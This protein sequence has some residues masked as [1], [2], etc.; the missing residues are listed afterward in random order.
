M[1]SPLRILYLEDDPRDAELVLETLALDGITCQLT[2]VENE[3]DFI[4]S[5][6][7]GGFDLILAD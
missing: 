7:Q 5:L 6:E 1:K 3:A 4:A 2:R